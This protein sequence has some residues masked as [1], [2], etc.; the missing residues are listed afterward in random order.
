MTPETRAIQHQVIEELHVRPLFDAAR[1]IEHRVAFLGSYLI[2]HGLQALVLGISGGIDSATA[3]RLAQLAIEQV[4]QQGHDARFIAMRLPYGR[5]VDERDAQRALA[6]IKPDEVQTVDI[7]GAS[8]AMLAALKQAGM[9]PADPQQEDFILGNI[10]ARQRMVAQY[11]VAG[12]RNGV[13][14]GTDHASEAVM[15]YFTK[16]GDYAC[17][18]GALTGLTKRRVRS[19]AT[20]LGMPQEIVR[21]IPTA[22]L[23]SLRPQRPAE[24]DFG[25]TFDQI[26]DFLEGQDIDEH[27]IQRILA[28]YQSTAH[29]RAPPPHP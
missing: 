7:Q 27:A 5:Q 25:V 13:V 28:A 2:H 14:V 24:D 8:D 15:G 29:K 17:D 11:A 22:D 18:L 16:H 21:K 20:S 23:E 6:F 3:G 4:R 12:C 26:D 9:H 1:E 19:I 10:K